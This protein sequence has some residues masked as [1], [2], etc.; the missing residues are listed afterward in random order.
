MF[1][2]IES[3]LKPKVFNLTNAGLRVCC[4]ITDESRGH[5]KSDLLRLKTKIGGSHFLITFF[6]FISMNSVV[7]NMRDCSQVTMWVDDIAR[8]GGKSVFTG[9]NSLSDT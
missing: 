8:A 7:L 9:K 6:S 3:N 4:F 2:G 5:P 1:C